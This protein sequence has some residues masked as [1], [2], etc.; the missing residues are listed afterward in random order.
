MRDNP[1]LD[2]NAI[3][4]FELSLTEEEKEARM[5]GRFLHLSGLVYK[6]FTPESHLV[7]DFVIPELW[8]RY[9]AIDPHERTPTA[10]MWVAV[11]PKGNKWVYDELW[12]GGVDLKT[13]ANAIHAQEGGIQPRIRLID[14]HNDKDNAIQ[15]GFNVRKELMKHGI[16]C[17]RANSDTQLGKSRI[18][19][20]LKPMY[21]HLSKSVTPALKIFRSCKQTIYEF[22]HYLWDDYKR[23]KEEYGIKDQVRKKDDHFMDC[24]RYIYNFEPRFMVEEPDDDDMGMEYKG[25]YTK[26]PAAPTRGSYHSLVEGQEQKGGRF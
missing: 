8:T 21:N 20:D 12:M 18:R 3:K 9:M 7:D 23:N 24:L 2:E 1:H 22:Q 11:D 4:E 13:I 14:P 6:E 26:Y 16:F 25:E 5:H 19:A 15:G 17:Q 10:V